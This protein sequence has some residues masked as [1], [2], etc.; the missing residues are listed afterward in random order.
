MIEWLYQYDQQREGEVVLEEKH[1]LTVLVKNR[2]GNQEVSPMEFWYFWNFLIFLSV[3]MCYT[4]E[5]LKRGQR[6]V[7]VLMN[8]LWSISDFWKLLARFGILWKKHYFFEF[9]LI[10]HWTQL[11]KLLQGCRS[12]FFSLAWSHV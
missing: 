5:L 9:S 8:F 11:P 6:P 1:N 7:W 2:K 3:I 4:Q 12:W 10:P